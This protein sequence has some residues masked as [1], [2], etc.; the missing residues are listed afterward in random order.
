MSSN[1][2]TLQPD[3]KH[4]WLERLYE[5]AQKF[6]AEI[7]WEEAQVEV[8]GRGLVW[9]TIPWIRGIKMTDCAGR[10]STKQEAKNDAAQLLSDKARLTR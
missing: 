7:Y 6:K 9:E 1:I 2:W 5:W 10:G 8:E 4:T 3:A